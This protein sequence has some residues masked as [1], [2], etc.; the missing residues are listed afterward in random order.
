MTNSNLN[1]KPN[2]KSK[3]ST[4]WLKRHFDDPYV[5]KSWESKYRSRAS[6]KLLEILEKDKIIK[7]GMIIVDLGAAPG[8]WSQVANDIIKDNGKLI[9][10]DILPMDPIGDIKVITGDFTDNKISEILEQELDNKKI[11][12]ILSDMAPNFSGN[13]SVDQPKSIYLNEL[14]LD[15]AINHLKP[16]GNFLCKTFQ[17]EG[18]QDFYQSVKKNFK[19]IISRNPKA[20]RD[21]STEIYLLGQ[22]K[23]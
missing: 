5:K 21:S 8:S 7:P 20:S 3:T 4:Q 11:D 2:K 1:Q 22:H 16:G 17:G 23:I 9:A 10:L 6:F 18:F 14:A 12:L 19:T 13:K 15:F